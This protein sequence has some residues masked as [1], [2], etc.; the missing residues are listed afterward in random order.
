M[1]DPQLV[2]WLNLGVRWLHVTTGIAWIGSSFYFNWQDAHLKA[3]SPPVEGS[4]GEVWMVHGG[5]FYRVE[6]YKLAPPQMP[7]DLHWFKWEAY[8]T[9]LSGIGLL[10][11]IYWLQA[12]L[13]LLDPAV[14]NLRAGPAVALAFGLL[15]GGW[16][17]YDALCRSPLARRP[18]AL[19]VVG[20]G[21]VTA[22]SWAL[23]E[24]FAARG[25][26]MHVGALL[27]TCMA[28]NVFFHIIP[29]QK[30]VVADLL[31]GREPDPSLGPAASLRSLHNNYMTLPVLFVMI[32]HHFPSTYGG[33]WSWLVLMALVAVGGATRHYFNRKNRGF[34]EPRW[35][36]LAAAGF[37]GLAIATRPPSPPPMKDG[38]AGPAFSEARAVL[39]TRCLPCHSAAPSDPTIAAPPL[40]VTFDTPAEIQRQA[41]RILERAVV[42]RT[43]PLGNK[44]AMTDE[45][46][47]LLGRWVHSGAGL[48]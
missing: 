44:T 47:E 40:G 42:A 1:A 25:A 14:S 22:I 32:S 43:M 28:G 3:A 12:D 37:V 17:G 24:F 21:A 10:A 5:G 19:A 4:L 45:E 29:N 18:M 46:R 34:I 13:Y 41:S 15:V 20:L 6:K 11:L 27:G 36:G 33:P 48:R 16:L 39:I 2:E 9:W 38:K 7:T 30:K 35:L 23:T 26:F 31:A 8:T